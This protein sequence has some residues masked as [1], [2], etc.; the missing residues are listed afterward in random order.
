MQRLLDVARRLVVGHH[1]LEAVDGREILLL[2]EIVAADLHLLAGELVARDVELGG[3]LHGIFRVGILLQQLAEGGRRLLGTHLVAA[4]VVDL[5]II[6]FADQVL[7]VGRVFAA[8]MHGHVALRRGDGVGVVASLEIGVGRHQERLARELRIRMDPVDFL[9]LLHRLLVGAAVQQE[10]PL[11]VELV[12]G[13][14]VDDGVFVAAAAEHR[15]AG[16]ACCEGRHDQHSE[17]ADGKRGDAARGRE[18]DHR[19]VHNRF[20]CRGV[21]ARRADFSQMPRRRNCN[22]EP[23]PLPVQ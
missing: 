23:S 8:G 16:S 15:A 21:S 2:A 19:F 7:R 6:R 12:G 1:R 10:Q 4:D 13:I 20:C 22:A 17:G 3:G 5:A 14:L 18:G 11:V 9:E